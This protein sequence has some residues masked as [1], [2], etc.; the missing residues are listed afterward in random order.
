LALY[1]RS[2]AQNPGYLKCDRYIQQAL[3]NSSVLIARTLAL[4]QGFQPLP[5]C[6]TQGL[7]LKARPRI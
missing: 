4:R 7:A 2:R 6:R 1:S 3:M 5:D